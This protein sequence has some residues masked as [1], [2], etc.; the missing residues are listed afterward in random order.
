MAGVSITGLS[1]SYMVGKNRFFALK[2]LDLFLPEH[3]FTAVVGKSGSGKTTLLRLLCGLEQQS[4]GRIEFSRGED[5]GLTSPKRVGIVFQ[6]P[7]LM[8][9][10]TVREN[11]AFSLGKEKDDPGKRER[12]EGCIR[13]L[14]LKEFADAY[15]SQISGGMAQRAALGRVLTYDPDVILMDEPFGALDYFTRKNLQKEMVELFLSQRKTFVFVTHDVEEAVYLSQKVVVLD[16]GRMVGEYAVDLPYPRQTSSPRFLAI[17][18]KIY[19]TIMN[20]QTDPAVRA[21]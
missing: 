7:R 8:P 14:G 11:I 4:G 1:K 9:W 13:L 2:G 5:A 10:L 6:E 18:D 21:V 19:D 15:P 16:E 17:R 3:S 12:V 20:G